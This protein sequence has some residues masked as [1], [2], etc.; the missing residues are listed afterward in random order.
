[1]SSNNTGSVVPKLERLSNLQ[2][3]TFI[4]PTKKINDGDGLTFFL[5]STAYGDLMTWLLQLNRSM[6]PTKDAE[7]KIQQNRMDSPAA[8]SNTVQNLIALISDFADL[9]EK[10]PPDTGPRRFGN[11]AFRTWFKLA[12]D[13]A[14][15]LC[16]KHL[17]SVLDKVSQDDSQKKTALKE[18]LKV[19]LLGSFGSAQRLDYGTGHELSFLAFLA[20]LWKLNAFADG[21]ERAIVIGVIQP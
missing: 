9:V 1:M 13:T 2:D 21:E 20:C 16:E 8:Y 3:H 15:Q 7:G 17:G 18:E 6:F 5:S 19:Y 4:T 14:D 11:V 12:E 10:A